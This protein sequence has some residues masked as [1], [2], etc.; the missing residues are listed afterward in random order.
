MTHEHSLGQRQCNYPELTFPPALAVSFHTRRTADSVQGARVRRF[1]YMSDEDLK[2]FY[3]P[4]DI[5]A[6][7]DPKLI[8]L[9]ISF[10]WK[11]IGMYWAI[12][13]ALHKEENGNIPTHILSSMIIDFYSQEEIRTKQHIIQEAEEFEECLYA[14]ALLE[15]CDG[16]ATSKRVQK[17][18]S[19]KEEKRLK[20]K[21]S[22]DIR[23]GKNPNRIVEKYKMRTQCDGNANAMLNSKGKES[24]Y[25]YKQPFKKPTQEEVTDYFK[26]HGQ[27]PL[28]SCG[29]F[30]FYESKGWFVGKTPMKDWKAAA[31]NWMRNKDKF[32]TQKPKKTGVGHLSGSMNG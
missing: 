22:A 1:F 31:R 12:I 27:P 13:E 19:I 5:G 15:R 3:F 26:S 11:S 6:S 17:N 7:N 9:R 14:N 8:N 2:A 25:I 32:N 24:K 30:D 21:A 20:A 16:I 29:F 4:H 10:G 28:E 18:L 23:W